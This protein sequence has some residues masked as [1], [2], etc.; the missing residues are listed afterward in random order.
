MA[1]YY[2]LE[3]A[4]RS[5]II[6]PDSVG[7]IVVT[8]EQDEAFFREKMSGGF[9]VVGEDY[10]FLRD[11]EVYAVEC[12]QEITFIVERDCSAGRE[13]FWEGYFTLYD[14]EWDPDNQ[15]ANV[16]K[17]VVRDKYNVIFS[18][19]H[20]EINWFGD[21]VR[22]QR[23][24][25]G[26]IHIHPTYPFRQ[27]SLQ[28]ENYNPQNSDN[29]FGFYFN[30]ML[31]WL[32]QQTIKETGFEQYADIT[33]QQMSEFLTAE[34]NPANG[35]QNYLKDVLITHISD[36]KRPNSTN[37]AYIGMVTLK[38]VLNDLKKL[39][40]AYWFIDD[41]D[42]FR[43]EHISYFKNF[44]Y[45]PAGITLDLTE[46]E[47]N[48][49]L[50]GK[51]KYSFNSEQLK[52][53]EGVEQ[54]LT[55][56]A[57]GQDSTIWTQLSNPSAKEFSAAYMSYGESCVP[58]NEKGE[59]DEQYQIISQFTTDWRTVNFKPDTVPDQGW[60]LMH[61]TN[62]LSESSINYGWLP[63]LNQ[64]YING[65]LAMSRLYYEFGRWDLSFQYGMMSFVK[66]G[67]KKPVNPSSNYVT[68][69]PMKA[70][71]TK[72]IKQFT[73]I[74]LDLCCGNSYDFSG[75]IKH[76]LDNECVVDRMEYD[77]ETETVTINLIAANNC[78]NI[79][80]PEY[81]EI[82]EPNQGC[83]EQGKNIR[84][85]LTEEYSAHTPI[86][87][88]YI[89]VFTDYFAD[90]ECGEYSQRREERSVQPKRGNGPRS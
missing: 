67:E 3:Y 8:R 72:R 44:S 62:F 22:A 81:V 33:E 57:F 82:T 85:E 76:P 48:E 24:A 2:R 80:F 7:K 11:A 78:D 1:F 9:T 68:E 88:V 71:S 83:P 30:Y 63:I 86:N 29:Y 54:S 47:Y 26:F 51:N 39:Y 87:Y 16:K 41:E 50:E 18:N 23:P 66:Q 56:G 58:K 21:I 69:R 10:N 65:S 46:E 5:Q 27:G 36:A 4:T 74:E 15:Q 35:K 52:G 45:V 42:H 53:R 49:R 40:N 13:I 73:P 77:L 89:K 6:T 55:I 38:D 84:S 31:L 32:V 17:V 43:I 79:P 20:K 60:V 34:I 25:A 64:S 61:I 14:V 70:K 75:F 19:W 37:P 12:C 28:S 59:S 90:G